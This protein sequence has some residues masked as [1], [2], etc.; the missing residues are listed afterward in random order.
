MP[1]LP[2][3]QREVIE[4]V[5]EHADGEW[6]AVHLRDTPLT[7]KYGETRVAKKVAEAG[8]FNW[9]INALNPWYQSEED[10]RDKLNEYTE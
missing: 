4:Y 6:D 9:G 1:D 3:I 2:N 10:V 7:E 5:L 8:V